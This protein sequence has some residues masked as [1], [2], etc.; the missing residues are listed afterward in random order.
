MDLR[1]LAN[2]AHAG[3]LVRSGGKLGRAV[4][5]RPVLVLE[6]RGRRSQRRRRTPVQYLRNEAGLVVVASNAGYRQQPAWRL[7]LEAE[8]AARALVDGSWV[9]V[10][11]RIADGEERERLWALLS[12]GNPWL[13]QA[14]R[15]A[16]RELPVIVLSPRP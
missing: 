13:V 1:L 4:G 9:N 5:G 12:D 11:A 7:N 15:R 3:L 14:A 6:T 16:R 10:V 2:R 8:P